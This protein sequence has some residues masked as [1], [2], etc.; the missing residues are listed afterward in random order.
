MPSSQSDPYSEPTAESD[1]TEDAYNSGRLATDI[2]FV[3]DIEADGPIPGKYS[4]LSLGL[5]VAGQ[6]D[7]AA[8]QEAD[9]EETTLYIEFKPISEAVDPEALAV[10]GLDR[11]RLIREGL[12]PEVAVP[13]LVEWIEGVSNQRLPVLVAHPLGFDWSF[14]Y[15]YMLAY[16]PHRSP[17]GHARHL[18][19]RTLW[20]VKSGL[21]VAAASRQRIPQTLRSKRPH[22]H[23][24]LD[25]AIEQAETFA[26][27]MVWPG[28]GSQKG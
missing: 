11:H 15:W 16:P 25:D 17:F 9:P 20:A 19:V 14:L 24:A 22:T 7:G 1:T 10:S 13:R 21:P 3:A 2:Y 26:R 6:Y 28:R 18:D 23:H 27:L 5:C 4:M 8:F 12:D